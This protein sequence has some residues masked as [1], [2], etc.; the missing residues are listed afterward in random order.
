MDP[1]TKPDMIV[2]DACTPRI[3]SSQFMERIREAGVTA[4]CVSLAGQTGGFF[5][6]MEEMNVYYNM[7][8]AFPNET[9]I[10][11]TTQDIVQAKKEGKLALIFS[12]Q[13]AVPV[14]DD[15][16]NR[17]P[18]LYRNGLRMVQLTYNETNRL[19]NGCFEPRD[20]GLTQIGIQIVRELNRL[21]IVIDLSHVGVQ[22]SLDAIKY[23]K[24]P[25]V[26]SHADCMSLCES[27]RNKTDE[28]IK[29]IAAKGGVIG[30]TPYAPFC[31]SVRDQRPTLEDYL[32]HIDYA[33]NLVGIDHVGIGTDIAEHW[34]VRW[35]GGTPRRYPD[36]TRNYTWETIYAE[37]FHS[38]ACFPDVFDALL[39]RGYSEEDVYKIAG[40]NFLR[41]FKQVWDK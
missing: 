10:A 31:E 17:L 30:F 6:S 33:V 23:S 16:V 35:A 40:G 2:V 41:I 5:E 15:W 27:V 22:T 28:Q 7:V 8:G 12:F 32:K 1:K 21:G 29:A 19:G 11:T 14:E 26:F 20:A 24:D 34:A 9:M 18:F 37:G 4:V 38:I 39:K 3:A 25:C 13:N 36:M